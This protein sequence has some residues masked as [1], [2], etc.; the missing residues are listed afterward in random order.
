MKKNTYFGLFYVYIYILC[1]NAQYSVK[2]VVL[3]KII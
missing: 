1:C 3:I 2:Q